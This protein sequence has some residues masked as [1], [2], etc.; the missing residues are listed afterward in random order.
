MSRPV[1]YVLAGVN[2]AGKSSV[3][4]HALIR[5]GLSWFDP[6]DFAAH[7]AAIS[8]CSLADAQGVAWQESLRRLEAAIAQGHDHAFETTL[9]GNTIAA[10]LAAAARTSHDVL[11]MFC[12]LSSPEQHIARVQLRVAGGGHPVSDEAVRAR[13]R[14]AHANLVALLPDLAEVQVY[15]N[16]QDAAPGTPVPDPRLLAHWADGRLLFPHPAH[17]AQDL[18]NTPDWAKPVVEA[19]LQL[20]DARPA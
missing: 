11:L 9:G 4:G 7:W 1:L 16:S 10:R 6:D 13:W 18:Q 17:H 12:G 8:G 14:S 19:M 2:G 3:L 5:Q 15:D 20:D